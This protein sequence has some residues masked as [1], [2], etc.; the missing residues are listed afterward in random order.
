VGFCTEIEA[1]GYDDCF[2]DFDWERAPAN[3]APFNAVPFTVEF[4]VVE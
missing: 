4:E 1:F 3:S 2:R